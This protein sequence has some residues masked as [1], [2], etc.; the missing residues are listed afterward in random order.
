MQIDPNHAEFTI[1][2]TNGNPKCW[3]LRPTVQNGGDIRK[4]FEMIYGYTMITMGTL[5]HLD[6]K[7][8][9]DHLYMVDLPCL[10]VW[11]P[12]GIIQI[13]IR[14]SLVIFIYPCA[15]GEL[16]CGIFLPSRCVFP[17]SKAQRGSLDIIG[18][19]MHHYASLCIIS[20]CH[21]R[22]KSVNMWIY[23]KSC[24]HGPS[25]GVRDQHILGSWSS[26]GSRPAWPPDQQNDPLDPSCV[27]ASCASSERREG[28]E[29][30]IVGRAW[31]NDGREFVPVGPVTKLLNGLCQSVPLQVVEI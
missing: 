11:L 9:Q 24:Y 27:N 28:L 23:G 6:G 26:Q 4:A 15:T 22:P 31:C 19:I 7:I 21:G 13:A 8:R 16:C 14:F 10:I 30:A 20:F 17:E 12:E 2:F 3:W 25:L 1:G 29:K 18:I 5:Q